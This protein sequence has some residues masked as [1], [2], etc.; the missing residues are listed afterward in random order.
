MTYL[1]LA[2]EGF[3]TETELSPGDGRTWQLVS[4]QEYRR[5]SS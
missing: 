5:I 3:I 2:A 4:R 1:L